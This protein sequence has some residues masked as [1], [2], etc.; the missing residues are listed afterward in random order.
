MTSIFSI[1]T[2]KAKKQCNSGSILMVALIFLTLLSIMGLSMIELI[3]AQ[4]KLAQIRIAGE[5]GFHVAEAGL[6]YGRWRLAHD[7]N[8][9]TPET[10]TYSDPEGGV[11]GTYS[12]TFTPIGAT[13]YNNTLVEIR[14]EGWY[15]NNPNIKRIVSARY[16]RRSFTQYSFLTNSNLY[17]SG[18]S[19][20]GKIHANGGI[21]MDAEANSAVTS[22]RQTYL[23]TGDDTGCVDIDDEKEGIWRCDGTTR[24]LWSYPVNNVDF[25]AITVDL[26]LLKEYAQCFDNPN[27]TTYTGNGIY[28]GNQGHGYHLTFNADGTV[29][30]CWIQSLEP[31][32][33]AYSIEQKKWI[34][35][36]TEIK[37]EQ[38]TETYTLLGND[39]IFIEDDVWVEGTVDGRVTVISA[40]LPE[41]PSSSPD[42]ILKGDLMYEDKNG[43]DVLG[44]LA[45]HDILIPL[46]PMN[47]TTPIPATGS[48]EVDAALLAQRDRFQRYFYY[49]AYNGIGEYYQFNQITLYGA[50][51]SYN[52]PGN[53][54]GVYNGKQHGVLSTVNYYDP[55]LL[56]NPPPYFPVT[57]DYDF[58]SWEEKLKGQP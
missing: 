43:D 9:L 37:N 27:C 20:D 17:F 53:Y 4:N 23:F 13:I 30:M 19:R 14:S 7:P 33:R 32:V 42:I 50:M 45:Q 15:G 22:A 26:S 39:L 38:C 47:G 48:Y 21:R 58:I 31:P 40:K 55:Q 35:L 57:G 12:L 1:H 44:L 41:V 51:I 52:Q 28:R 34:M 54:W 56:Y 25:N 11:I 8:D 46:K 6:N 3:V 10:R 29:S 5:Y 49:W 2:M 16:G 24:S 18:G 36:S